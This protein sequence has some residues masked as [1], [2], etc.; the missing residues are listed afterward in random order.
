MEIINNMI[1]IATYE[2]MSTGVSINNI[3]HVHFP[4]GGR[5]KF[6][7]KQGTGRI[8][9]LYNS[10]IVAQVF[11]YQDNMSRSA[12]KNHAKERNKIYEDEQHPSQEFEVTI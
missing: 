4:N 1:L 12:F 5:S 11:D 9:R 8:V 7:V 3:H 2:T 10:K 6:R